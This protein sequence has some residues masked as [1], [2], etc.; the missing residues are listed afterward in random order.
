[1]CATYANLSLITVCHHCKC[2][3]SDPKKNLRVVL[4]VSIQF[5]FITGYLGNFPSKLATSS[6][7]EVYYF[8]SYQTL[9]TYY[10]VAFPFL[11]C[12]LCGWLM[13]SKKPWQKEKVVQLPSVFGTGSLRDAQFKL[14]LSVG[15]NA[16]RPPRS[17]SIGFPR[18]QKRFTM[19]IR[20]DS[21]Y[22]GLKYEDIMRS[23]YV[24][25]FWIGV[26]NSEGYKYT[27]LR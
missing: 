1:M 20:K 3:K 24:G 25:S 7:T 4:I 18:S 22:L 9:S 13:L 5:S 2:A 15:R 27:Y 11:P 12:T 6:M 17:P 26:C 14:Q 16:S 19:L 8:Y 10:L 21:S 23:H